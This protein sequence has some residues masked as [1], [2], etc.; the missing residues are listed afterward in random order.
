MHDIFGVTP[1]GFTALAAAALLV[2]FSKT[3][4]SGANTVSLAV[5]A[6]VLPARASTGVPLP[7]LICGDILAVLTYRRHAHW[8][9]LWRLFPAVA[10]GVLLGT[11][12]LGFAGDGAVRMS[13]GV[14]LLVM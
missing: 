12:F 3:A 11:V 8:P 10:G 9:T 13:I 1:W 5:F 7:L 2:G 14:I 4:V 6:A